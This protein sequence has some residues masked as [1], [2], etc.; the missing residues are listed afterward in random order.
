MLYIHGSLG[1]FKGAASH[2]SISKI[3]LTS[4]VCSHCLRVVLAIYKTMLFF[5][6]CAT[7]PALDILVI[8]PEDDE[9]LLPRP[10]PECHS[11]GPT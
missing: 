2:S 1:G 11:C 10:V 9:N 3:I 8:I 6:T 7:I 4:V 5:L